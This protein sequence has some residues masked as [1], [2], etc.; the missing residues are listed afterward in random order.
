MYLPTFYSLPKVLQKVGGGPLRLSDR[1]KRSLTKIKRSRV[2][3]PAQPTFFKVISVNN[4][5][6]KSFVFVV[7]DHPGD[8]VRQPDSGLRQQRGQHAQG[9]I[10]RN[11]IFAKKNFSV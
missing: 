11:C 10:L 7:A 2:R 9:S 8:A 3:S 1:K 5:R 4:W 6:Q